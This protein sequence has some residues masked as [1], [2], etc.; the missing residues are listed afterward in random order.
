MKKIIFIIFLLGTFCGFSQKKYPKG[1]N[2]IDY[3]KIKFISTNKTF[4]KVT[5][6][7]PF[8]KSNAQFEIETIT[9]PQFI[10]KS[11]TS[12]P[13]HKQSVKLGRVFLLS[14][15]AKTTKSSLETGEAKINLLFKQ[16]ESYKNNIV[17]TQSISSKWQQYYIPFQSDINID[18][19]N[20]GI[21]LHY[22]FK[23]QAFLIKDIK[24]EL[25]AEGTKFEAL[26]K[27]EIVYKGMEPDAKWRKEANARIEKNRK[28]DFK[29]Q[30]QKKGKAITDKT[31]SIKLIKHNFPFGAAI[32]AKDVVA[33]NEKYK[34][35]KKAFD[36][37]VFE[38]DL[39]IKS[40]RW[41]KK[42]DQL[43]EA[44]SILKND[45]VTIKGHVLIWPG[46]NYL[47]PEIK[48]NKDNPEKVTNLIEDHVTNLLK[49]TKD[50][51]SH[52]DVVNEAYT[53]R[54]LQQITG[55]EAILYNGFKATKELQPIAKCFINE[56][57]IISKGGLDTKKQEWYYNFIK[58]I[59]KN[60]GGLVDGIGI[61]SHIGSDLTPPE[62]VL[63][64]LDYYGTLNIKISISEFTMDIQEPVI[65]EQYTRDF[66][67]AAFSHPNVSEFLFWGYVE[68]DRKKVDIYK[69]DFTIGA[70]GKAYFSLINDVWK[71][72]FIGKTNDK[73]TILGNGF[74][75]TYEY[76]FVD[77]S[78]VVKGEFQL[79]PNQ[80]GIINVHIK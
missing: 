39:K 41:K 72:D 7:E 40:L 35:F 27:T 63:E 1:E 36:L 19:N 80:N 66:M 23:P 60:T 33:N 38:N 48:E 8:K 6:I 78:R 15:S 57:G 18:Q 14:F 2:L 73:G 17:S 55:S 46:F 67:I 24:F 50:K 71:T 79:N 62:K 16:S 25:F 42:K 70:M 44:I 21:V 75:G 61:Q 52:W 9:Q 53:N 31:I 43:I 5:V 68:D 26:P 54:D 76:S 22:G 65:R 49:L 56:Y 37:A 51:I 28:S 77:G 59:D 64:I 20:L 30:F 69:K 12:I 58:R 74:Y 13:I 4:G 11:A 32:N 47:T 29:I 10:Y 45:N 3:N 34:N